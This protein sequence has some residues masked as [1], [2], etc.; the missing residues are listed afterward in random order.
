MRSRAA[1]GLGAALAVLLVGSGVMRGQDP[2]SVVATVN[3]QKV[4]LANLEGELHD[5]WIRDALQAVVEKALI[6]QA[7]RNRNLVVAHEEVVAEI[8]RIRKTFADETAFRSMLQERGLTPDA[9]EREVQTQLLLSKLVG[10]QPQ[11]TEAEAQRYYDTHPEEFA[12]VGR[13]HLYAILTASVDDAH[14]AAQRLATGERFED[15][16]KAMSLDG[17]ALNGGDLGW[18][19]TDEIRDDAVAAQAANLAVNQV[20][21]PFADSRGQGWILWLKEKEA[22]GRVPFADVKGEIMKL[23]SARQG[24]TEESFLAGL[25]RRSNVQVVHPRF[26]YMTEY[27]RSKKGIQLYVDGKHIRVSP[28]PIIVGEGRMLVPAKPV[29]TAMGARVEWLDVTRSLHAMTE[30]GEVT[31]QPGKNQ[32]FVAATQARVPLAQAPVLREGILYIPVKEVIPLLGGSLDW[33]PE[34]NALY[35][36]SVAQAA[37]V[38]GMPGTGLAPLPLPD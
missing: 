28:A 30:R 5:Y 35:I 29:L 6:Q 38:T 8:A 33:R 4:T 1:I 21:E 13:L 37:P 23:L 9:Y 36:K 32:A 10:E 24:R 34:E 26:A 11:V 17:S 15:V 14:V 22:G 27:Y 16:A 19:N 7:A 25:Y 2:N 12:T 20:T 31:L 3:G 18:L